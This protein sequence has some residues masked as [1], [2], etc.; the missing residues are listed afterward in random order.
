MKVDALPCIDAMG[1]RHPPVAGE[2]RIV[3]LVPSITELLF[4]L[5]LWP[6]VVGRTGYCVYPQGAVDSVPRVGGTKTADLDKI[7]ALAATHVILNVDENTR[8][9]ADALA[10]IVPHV[11]VTH[12]MGPEDNPHLYRLLGSVFRRGPQAEALCDRFDRVFG[13]L[14]R[15]AEHWP[16]RR[17]LYLIWR[18]PYMTV[19]RDTYISRTLARAGWDT[20]AHDS[21]VR[22][23]TLE[24]P[25]PALAQAD[26]VLLS[27]EP[28]PFKPKH[29]DELRRGYPMAEKQAA[30]IDAEMVSWYGSR[31]ISGMDYLSGY[32]PEVN[33]G[34]CPVS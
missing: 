32:V 4:D 2:A 13:R 9:L 30:I 3:S 8:V 16:R 10:E 23:P 33:A 21:R 28:F 11:V 7:R 14:C 26:L 27:S 24:D 1:T 31:A 22:Y 12:P 18:N 34:A 15:L 25:A 29:L 17:V 19:S 5:G 6:S 20:V